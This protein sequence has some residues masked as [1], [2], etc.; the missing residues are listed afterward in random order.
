MSKRSSC[1]AVALCIVLAPAVSMSQASA[2]KPAKCDSLYV[3]FFTM[4]N[5]AYNTCAVDARPLPLA[6]T[7]PS[8]VPY[9]LGEYEASMVFVV[10]DDGQVDSTTL[11]VSGSSGWQLGEQTPLSV[12]GDWK[13]AARKVKFSSGALRGAPV[14]TAVH[15]E[16]AVPSAPDSVPAVA[17][18]RYIVGAKSDTMRLE[19]TAG[20]PLTPGGAGA[21]A[22]ALLAA[23][24]ELRVTRMD[25]RG[26][27]RGWNGC[28]DIAVTFPY[29]EAMR[30]SARKAGIALSG[31]PR[32]P[33][34]DDPN[35]VRWT[36]LFRVSESEFVLRVTYP[37]GLDGWARARCWV[38]RIENG[39]RAGCRQ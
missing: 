39:W 7:I 38:A 17:T 9:W 34:S 27:P 8:G 23:M 1:L 6:T 28:S 21:T 35:N 15:L 36:A 13:T 5:E 3:S 16:L 4:K 12:A 24:A 14:R 22:A 26:R 29:A 37:V 20:N 2:A 10:N 19:W 30:E 32:C 11:D 31:D 33:V 25:Y 18:W